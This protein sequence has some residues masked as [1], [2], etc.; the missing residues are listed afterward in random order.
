[1][2]ETAVLVAVAYLWG[3]I[4]TTY[5]FARYRRGVDLR[6]F[7]SGNVG[8][9]NLAVLAGYPVALTLGAFDTFGKGTLP[10]LLAGSVLD[11][12][13][14]VQGAVGIAAVVGHNWSPYI[15]FTGG[16]GISTAVGVAAG[17]L[18]WREALIQIFLIAVV[19]RYIFKDAGLWTLIAVLAAPI[20]AYAFGQPPELVY[21]L[22][23]VAVV[24]ILKRLTANWTLPRQDGLRRVMMRRLLWD[25]D[26]GHKEEW[27]TRSQPPDGN[28]EAER[29]GT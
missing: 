16:R 26:V 3:G 22:S 20:V 11:Q 25:R 23:C 10:V 19:G 27:T 14:Y 15:K 8:A 21:V 6:D 13:L 7:G 24:L 4:P 2:L 12:D 9:S 28:A 29:A 17:L 18:M 1:M 5:L